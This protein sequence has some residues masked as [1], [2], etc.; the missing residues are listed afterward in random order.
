VYEGALHGWTHS[1]GPVYHPEQA[2]RAFEKLS[3]L[4]AA[5]LG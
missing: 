1:D 5:Q 4:L 2:A 3:E